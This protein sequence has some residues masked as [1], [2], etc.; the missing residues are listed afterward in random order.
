MI[1]AILQWLP[2]KWYF[3]LIYLL[4]RWVSS[5]FFLSYLILS[6]VS[7]GG[8]YFFVFLTNWS[9]IALNLHLL[10][11]AV[12]AT[13]HYFRIYVFCKEKFEVQ[14]KLNSYRVY[15]EPAGCCGR[16]QDDTAWYQKV[17]W[18]LFT[19]GNGAAITV[20]ILY[21]SLIYGLSGG[22]SVGH[23][24]IVI[25]ALNGVIAVIDVGVS[26]VPV[27]ILHFVYF[28][29]YCASYSVFTGVYYGAGG[30]VGNRT[31]IYPV[32]NYESAPAIASG[33]VL[34]ST[35]L[36]CP[37]VHLAVWGLYLAREGLVYLVKHACSSDA[38]MNDDDEEL[39][40][41]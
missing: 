16:Q 15:D 31:Y 10:W 34:G 2:S 25:H 14:N 38:G 24:G 19:I 23:I 36:V 4:Y 32:L 5:L 40:N 18:I 35:L 26:G 13:V 17:Q 9:L 11:S 8:N 7:G 22:G 20:T 37:L 1:V 21:W 6:G 41:V 29:A 30:T 33:T 12:F 39:K 28:I 27:R 3:Q